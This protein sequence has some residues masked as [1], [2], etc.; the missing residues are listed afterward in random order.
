MSD[1]QPIATAP[2]DGTDILLGFRRRRAVVAHGFESVHGWYF[3]DDD[4]LVVH[5]PTHWMP[6]P[7]PPREAAP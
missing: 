7:K 2:R 3:S 5:E 4:D 1:W 6:I